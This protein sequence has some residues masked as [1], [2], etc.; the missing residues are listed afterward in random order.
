M[1]PSL[2]SNEKKQELEE[3]G[4]ICLRGVL[5]EEWLL[6]LEWGL[7]RNRAYPGPYA[8]RSYEGTEYEFIN[9][10]YNFDTIPEY[11]N[12]L[13]HSPVADILTEIIDS[14]GLWLYYDQFFL[15]EGPANPTLW[16]QD[17]EQ[18]ISVGKKQATM[19]ISVDPL[20]KDE[21]LNFIKGTHNLPY[22][23]DMWGKEGETPEAL[24]EFL[25]DREDRI[26]ELRANRREEPGPPM[27][28]FS[29]PEYADQ[30]LGW[31]LEPGDVIV[32]RNEVVHGGAPIAEGKIRRSLQARCFGDEVVFRP[33]KGAQ[34]PFPHVDVFCKPGEL[35]RHPHYFPQLRPKNKIAFRT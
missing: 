23:Y 28:D 10:S 12:F 18:F 20:S 22:F 14:E 15:K 26:S 33:H 24:S 7:E 25:S 34:P 19:W 11:R 21:S 16:H 4:A 35:L 31:D 8:F 3:N 17:G 9:D 5:D 2:V 1:C 27:P 13:Y 29:K 32:F 30:I 6:L